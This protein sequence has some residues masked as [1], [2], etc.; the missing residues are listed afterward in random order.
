MKATRH[1][2][3]IVAFSSSI[4]WSALAASTNEATYSITKSLYSTQQKRDPFTPPGQ[5]G[6]VT[7]AKP[8]G[9]MVF[10]LDGILYEANAPSASINGRLVRLNKPIT[11]DGGSGEVRVT[12][13]EITREKV[14]L[15][16]N[17]QRIELKINPSK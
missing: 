14:V 11:I 7:R 15:E 13:V 6:Y 2:I 9:P 4:A 1:I 8:A 3:I 17:G 16:A 5:T 10:R 12:A